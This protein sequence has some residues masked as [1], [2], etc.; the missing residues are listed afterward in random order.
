MDL[1]E[2]YKEFKLAR[3][4]IVKM[5]EALM[6]EYKFLIPDINDDIIK[7]FVYTNLHDLY[8]CC[9]EYGMKE[10]GPIEKFVKL[11]YKLNGNINLLCDSNVHVL[12]TIRRALDNEVL[13]VNQLKDTCKED[14]RVLII[15]NESFW[16]SLFNERKYIND[17]DFR[18]LIDVELWLEK[19]HDEILDGNVDDEFINKRINNA[20][21]KLLTSIEGSVVDSDE[22]RFRFH[23]VL[24][25][26]FFFTE[27]INELKSKKIEEEEFVEVVKTNIKNFD[28]LRS[29]GFKDVDIIENNCNIANEEDD[30]EEGTRFGF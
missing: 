23:V 28:L 29:S 7:E 5:R 1:I 12:T 10:N 24:C 19:F 9:S 30:E 8:S 20:I 22:Q 21:K 4:N 26:L 13:T 14:E 2:I 17:N 16:G 6:K 25:Y 27:L 18:Y 11:F 15:Y 3:S